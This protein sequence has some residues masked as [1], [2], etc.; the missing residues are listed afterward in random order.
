MARKRCLAVLLTRRTPPE[1]HMN[2]QKPEQSYDLCTTIAL[3]PQP[4]LQTLEDGGGSD[5]AG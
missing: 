5:A 3:T 1:F 2:G 4:P